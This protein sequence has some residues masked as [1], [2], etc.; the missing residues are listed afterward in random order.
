MEYQWNT[1]KDKSL[2]NPKVMFCYSHGWQICNKTHYD[3]HKL[4]CGCLVEY[5]P[6]VY[7]HPKVSDFN[8]NK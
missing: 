3:K 8:V 5:T 7:D 6:G 2:Q 4:N 1:M